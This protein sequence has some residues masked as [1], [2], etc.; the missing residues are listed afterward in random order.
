[1]V[2]EISDWIAL[3]ALETSFF[4]LVEAKAKIGSECSF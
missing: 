2:T 4:T 3:T 1:M